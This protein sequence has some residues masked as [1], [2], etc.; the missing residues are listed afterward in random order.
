MINITIKK[1]NQKIIAIEVAG[2]SG[3]AVSGKDIVCS[4]ISTLTES[5]ING[6]V[7]VV[8]I[9]DCYTI[10]EKGPYLKVELPVNLDEKKDHD[11]QIL[12]LST[13]NALQNICDSYPKFI[14]IKEKQY[15]QD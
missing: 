8:E 2:H 9:K 11:S 4:A 14:K 7:D 6:L 3:Y 13:V 1:T 12:M 15:D 5:L 10:D